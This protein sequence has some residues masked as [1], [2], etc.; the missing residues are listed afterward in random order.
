MA[1]KKEVT[2][3][4][5]LKDIINGYVMGDG[6]LSSKGILTVDQGEKQ[7]KFVEWLYQK[8]KPIC[9]ETSQIATVIR[10]GKNTETKSC[11]FNTRA[12]LK[13][14]YSTWYKPVEKE[15]TSTLVEPSSAELSLVQ[16]PLPKRGSALVGLTSAPEVH[17]EKNKKRLPTNIADMFS[18]LFITVWFACHGT[19]IL[20][21]RGA[22]FEVTALSVAEREVLKKLF[23]SKYDISVQ[24]NRSGK[25]EK[26]NI[27]WVLAVNSSEYDKFRDLITQF[28]L[29]PNLFAYKL[30]KKTKD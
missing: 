1:K 29:I 27:Q 21:S 24:I 3:S 18:P 7:R 19:K 4:D 5:E 2:L 11:R 22:K 9:T 13:E 12:V 15:S 16:A 6:Y 17:S 20:G 14:Y 26:K 25:T 23:Q 30:H 8:L 28:D 10:K